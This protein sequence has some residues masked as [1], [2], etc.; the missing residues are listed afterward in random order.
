MA[1]GCAAKINRHKRLILKRRGKSHF[2]PLCALIIQGRINQSFL[3]VIEIF[4]LFVHKVSI[5]LRL[6]SK[7]HAPADI[8]AEFY[9]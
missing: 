5:G 6:A 2:A 9:R 7:D 4:A 8:F 3:Y 1:Q